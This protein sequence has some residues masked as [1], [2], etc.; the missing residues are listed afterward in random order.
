MLPKQVMIAGMV[1]PVSEVQDLQSPFHDEFC[2]GT[3][4]HT[5]PAIQV[6]S[7]LADSVKV[8]ALLHEMFH[9]LFHQ[10]GHTGFDDEERIVMML[11]CQLPSLI[12]ANRELFER[13]L[14]TDT[15]VTVT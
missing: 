11:G 6:E 3:V 14:N 4:M 9:A 12:R 1:Y 5:V 8:Q 10:T 15:S 7:T 13:I 2:Y